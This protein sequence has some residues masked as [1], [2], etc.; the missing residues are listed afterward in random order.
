MFLYNMAK[1]SGTTCLFSSLSALLQE[2]ERFKV[3]V[4]RKPA[5]DVVVDGL[6]VANLTKD[7]TQL[8]ETV[9]KHTDVH[10]ECDITNIS[11]GLPVCTQFYNLEFSG[12]FLQTL[13][14]CPTRGFSGSFTLTQSAECV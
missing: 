14:V 9:R 10:V 8:S 12:F 11:L 5:F 3:F 1:Y 7:K 2:L 4:K 6:N 13:H